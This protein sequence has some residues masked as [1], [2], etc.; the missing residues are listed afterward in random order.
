[1]LGVFLYFH[2]GIFCNCQS[3]WR[4]FQY[5][6]HCLL[7]FKWEIFL[8]RVL[9]TPRVG[10]IRVFLTMRLMPPGSQIQSS[11][12][13]LDAPPSSLQFGVERGKKVVELSPTI[14]VLPPLSLSLS[15]QL[16]NTIILFICFCVNFSP[17]YFNFLFHS[18][19]FYRSFF[20]L[21]LSPSITLFEM[22]YF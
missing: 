16:K 1:M 9:Y 22:F 13:S 2:T 11:T 3:Y 8:A 4:E 5:F 19:F 14:P 15:L 10:G 21:Q 17:Y 20:I 12:V 7:I 18:D 6:S